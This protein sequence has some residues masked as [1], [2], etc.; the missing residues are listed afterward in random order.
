MEKSKYG[1]FGR[2]KKKKGYNEKDKAKFREGFSGRDDLE[3]QLD[4]SEEYQDKKRKKKDGMFSGIK[5]LF[6]KK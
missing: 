6:S 4:K 3:V 2:I 5:S 1:M